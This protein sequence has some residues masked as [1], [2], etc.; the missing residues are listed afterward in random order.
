M[1]IKDGSRD[2]STRYEE[3]PKLVMGRAIGKDVW[4]VTTSVDLTSRL[5]KG[6]PLGCEPTY[7]MNKR[8]SSTVVYGKAED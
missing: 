2:P 4:G 1:A 3:A 5:T 8:A 6:K 7:T